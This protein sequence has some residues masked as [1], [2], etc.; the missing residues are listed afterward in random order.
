MSR[1]RKKKR[2]KE[3]ESLQVELLQDGDEGSSQPV[4]SQPEVP[5][6]APPAR[7][8]S[9]RWAKAVGQLRPSPKDDRRRA[10]SEK[11]SALPEDE[12]KVTARD[13]A[14]TVRPAGEPLA[15]ARELVERGRIHEAIELYLG[16][17]TV[18][19]SNLKAHNNLG[20]LLD[21]L[22]QYEAALEHFVAA[23]RLAPE[24]VEVLAN[25]ASTL[26]SLARYEEAE[27]LLRRAQ[28]LAPDDVLARL[29]IGVLYFRRGL[30]GNAEAELGW[31]CARD[32]HNGAAYYYRG[33][34][35]N[36]LSRFDEAV[37]AME[38]AALLIPGDPRPFYTLGHLYDR[39]YRPEEA[40]EMYRRA[41]E[42]QNP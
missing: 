32:E 16:I 29:G 23:E 24:N 31:V 9:D 30:Y 7:E 42:L 17:L 22:K 25:F 3:A 4:S 12:A 14:A 11:P 33:E 10:A 37:D 36:R 28:R 35:L 1:R 2:L 19:P 38:R 40:A 5:P 39:G 34:A 13:H 27:A 8:T 20:V 6:Q 21:E 41:R 26:T 15:R 18:N